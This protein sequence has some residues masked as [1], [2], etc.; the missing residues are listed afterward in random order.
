MLTINW[1]V[2]VYF[3]GVLHVSIH[4]RH[5]CR[6]CAARG[7][8][9]RLGPPGVTSNTPTAGCAVSGGTVNATGLPTDQ[10]INFFITDSTGKTG[11]VLGFTPDGTW[12]VT[13][14]TKSPHRFMGRGVRQ[15]K[16]APQRGY[17]AR[18]SPCLYAPMLLWA[19]LL[20]RHATDAPALLMARA[21][22]PHH[23]A[24]DSAHGCV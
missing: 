23:R 21:S 24:A 14:Q 4:L 18:L 20:E 16:R 7:A 10:A 1:D 17:G 8:G 2:G 15:R 13:V 3:K 22:N 5:R 19:L 11:W 12:T 9:D 6:W